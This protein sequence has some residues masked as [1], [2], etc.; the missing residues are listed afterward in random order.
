VAR[1]GFERC[2]SSSTTTRSRRRASSSLLPTLNIRLASLPDLQ[3]SRVGLAR[4]KES[5]RGRRAPPTCEQGL[6]IH[7]LICPSTWTAQT[8]ARPASAASVGFVR[9]SPWHGCDASPPRSLRDKHI[10][11]W[12]LRRP[13]CLFSP[14]RISRS[15][16]AAVKLPS[17]RTHTSVHPR[18][19]SLQAN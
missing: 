13:H 14:L 6:Y 15:S 16:R 3:R 19:Q 12:V 11:R 2:R 5:L 10:C 1:L 8:R 4:V 18:G 17:Q 7:P 9:Q